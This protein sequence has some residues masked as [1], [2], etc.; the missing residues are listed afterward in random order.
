ML[1]PGNASNL[2]TATDYITMA[3]YFL[4]LLTFQH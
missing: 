3:D 1:K 2:L 4:L